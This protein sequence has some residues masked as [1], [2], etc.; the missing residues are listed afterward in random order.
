MLTTSLFIKPINFTVLVVTLLLIYIPS[1]FANTITL[2]SPTVL[3]G[4]KLDDK[5]LK[6]IK[7]AITKAMNG[8]IDAEHQCG[9]VRLDC[10]VRAARQWRYEGVIYREIVINIHTVGHASVTVEKTKGKWTSII[11]K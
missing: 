7:D 11:I 10:V 6:S 5:Q 1:G 4:L 9:A 2:T 3:G 8:P